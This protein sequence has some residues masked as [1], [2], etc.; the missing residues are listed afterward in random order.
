MCS[1]IYRQESGIFVLIHLQFHHSISRRTKFVIVYVFNL[2]IRAAHQNL[3][4]FFVHLYRNVKSMHKLWAWWEENIGGLFFSQYMNFRWIENRNST[5]K[6]VLSE[7]LL[8]RDTMKW[9]TKK[10][11]A[12]V[13]KLRNWVPIDCQKMIHLKYWNSVIPRMEHK[14]KQQLRKRKWI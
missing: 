1:D 5:L 6:F 10:C 4:D 14:M 7:M 3:L 11:N 12:V 9:N 2:Y 8:Q 13:E